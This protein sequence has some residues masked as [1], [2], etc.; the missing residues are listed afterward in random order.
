MSKRPDAVLNIWKNDTLMKIQNLWRYPVKGLQGEPLSQVAIEAKHPF[1]LDRCF[2]LA[3]GD[4]GIPKETP[5]WELKTSFHMLMHKG[6]QRLASLKPHFDEDTNMLSIE[7]EGTLVLQ[8]NV[9]DPNGVSVIEKFFKT[10][11]VDECPTVTPVFVQSRNMRFGNIEEP[12]ISLINLASVRSLSSAVDK[13]VDIARFRGN[14]IVD[15]GEA[16]EERNWKGRTIT[17][18][19]INFDVVDEIIRCGATAV[20][21]ASFERDLN[22]PGLLKR[23][24]DHLFCG[25]YLIAKGIGTITSGD[26][27]TAH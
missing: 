16:W 17:I 22:V 15:G 23:N 18:N 9:K 11:L 24:F 6:D 7:C 4:A 25:V 27:V 21:P 1:P 3:H 13:D 12:V 10:F 8:E 5:R 14:I 26:T 19:G 2:A 20:N